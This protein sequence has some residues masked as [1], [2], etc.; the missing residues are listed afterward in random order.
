LSCDCG[1]AAEYTASGHLKLADGS[2][3]TITAWDEKQ[4]KALKERIGVGIAEALFRDEVTA[5][6]IREDHTAEESRRAVL[7]AYADRLMLDDEP[8]SGEDLKGV[9]VFSRNVLTLLTDRQYE[10]R[11]QMSFN[12]LKYRYWAENIQSEA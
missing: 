3:E 6:V 9:A 11:G 2:V 1:F 4:R 12:A 5:R 7:T 10:I 8:I